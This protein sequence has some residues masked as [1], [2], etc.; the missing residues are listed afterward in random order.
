MISQKVSLL[1]L[2]VSSRTAVTLALL[3]TSIR[4]RNAATSCVL[5]GLETRL[6]EALR[7]ANAKYSMLQTEVVHLAG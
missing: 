7:I 5:L 2:Q 6:G 3:K 4:L 1:H